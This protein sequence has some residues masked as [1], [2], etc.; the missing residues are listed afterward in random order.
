M[1][2]NIEKIVS[3]IVKKNSQYEDDRGYIAVDPDDLKKDI[4]EALENKYFV[5]NLSPFE[6]SIIQKAIKHRAKILSYHETPRKMLEI[7]LLEYDRE[8]KIV[9]NDLK[10]EL[11]LK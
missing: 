6:F 11:N 7:I 9:E 1:N 8:L 4:I 2:E 5:F 10:A 3:D